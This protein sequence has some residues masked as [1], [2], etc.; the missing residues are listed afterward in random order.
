MKQIHPS[1]HF[2]HANPVQ[3]E[4]SPGRVADKKP[5]IILM[6]RRNDDDAN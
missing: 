4:R 3:Q 2:S 5:T 1:T 6:T